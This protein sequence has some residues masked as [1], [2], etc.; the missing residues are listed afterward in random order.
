[1][2][3]L[4]VAYTTEGKTDKRF[5][6]NIIRK[7]F[8]ELAFECTGQ[9]E[10]FE[11]EH[12][13]VKEESF[14]EHVVSAAK[15]AFWAHVLCVHTDADHQSDDVAFK[16]K[17]NPSLLEIS[18]SDESQICRNV[19]AVVP[20]QMTEAWMLADRDLF[21]R[22]INTTKN[23]SELGLPIRFKQIESID[24][25][26]R[27]IEEAIRISQLEVPR[28]RQKISIGDIYSPISQ[29]IDLNILSNLASYQKFRSQ[30]RS[31]LKTLNYLN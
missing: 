28:R 23:H 9:I 12:L 20:I 15:K 22:E 1:M 27:T 11:P 7:T 26:K 21:C 4:T 10:V 8:E 6:G 17:I 16:N 14:V 29:K 13:L 24:N 3:I 2:N 5:L 18:K 31:A 25:P 19:V 30:A